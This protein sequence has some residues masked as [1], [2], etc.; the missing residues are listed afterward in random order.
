MPNA[1]GQLREQESNP[2]ILGYEPSETPFL[3]PS[4]YTNRLKLAF[5]F[6]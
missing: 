6:G 3:H 4:S 5:S 1:F 2:L